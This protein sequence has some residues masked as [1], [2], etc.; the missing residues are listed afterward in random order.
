MG[1]VRSDSQTAIHKEIL[2]I[3]DFQPHLLGDQELSRKSAILDRFWDK[4]KSDSALYLPAL[5]KELT[6]FSN[7]PF[8]L[9]DGSMLLLNLSKDAPDRKI[10]LAAIAHCDLRDVQPQEYFR[11]IH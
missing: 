7:P 10:A 9:Y 8:F 2:D 11:Q 4:A 6:D 5:R 1:G 3:Y